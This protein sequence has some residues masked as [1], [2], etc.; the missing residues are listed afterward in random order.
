MPTLR[1]PGSF[2]RSSL[3]KYFT[4][5][6]QRRPHTALDDKTPDEFYFD[7]LPVMPKAA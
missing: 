7:N 5:Y 4:F 6:N 2:A 1:S 3:E